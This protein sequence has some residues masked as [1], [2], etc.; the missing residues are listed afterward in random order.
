MKKENKTNAIKTIRAFVVNVLLILLIPVVF[1]GCSARNKLDSVS[2]ALGVDVSSGSEASN[3]DTH[4]G[5]GDGTSCI[6]LNFYDD[7]VLKEIKG[8]AEWKAFPLD[9]TVQTLV[10]GTEDETG[11]YG[12]YLT[13]DGNPLVPEIQNGYYLLIDRQD[14]NEQATEEDIL[15]R[16]SFNF[17]LGLYDTDTNTLYFCQLDT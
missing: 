13:D 17:S 10:Y 15:H 6:V 3:Y 4:S 16:S 2:E 5:N 8:K 9:E 7:T 1:T 12:P 11:K 14:E